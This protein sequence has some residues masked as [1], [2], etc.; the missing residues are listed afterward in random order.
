MRPRIFA[1][2][3]GIAVA[4]PI[5]EKNGNNKAIE[6]TVDLNGDGEMSLS[7]V[8][9]AAFVHHG[10]GGTVVEDLFKQA[11]RNQ[12]KF[13]DAEEFNSIKPLVLAKAENA[14]A[15]YM[16]NVD[17]DRN[18]M[19]S[20][21][22]AQAY[23][24]KE[25]GIGARDVER[26]WKMVETDPEAEMAA[27]TFSKLRRRIR[28]M[29][30]RLA[31]QVM[32][33]AD[34]NS[35][36]H[37]SREEA[38]AIA[39]EQEG[40]GAGD[41][42]QIFM[43]VDDNGDNELNA[44][45]FADFERIVRA[46][47][48]GTSEKALKLM[49]VDNTGTITLNEARQIAF[50]HYGFGDKLLSQ[51]FAQA[52]ENEDGQLNAVEFAGFRSV[53]RA[54]AV[55]NAIEALKA[56]DLDGD[57]FVSRLEA[58]EKTHREDDLEPSVTNS[59]FTIAD[60]NKSGKL[61]KV[62]LA[63]FLRLARLSAI[64]FAAD[65]FKEFDNNQD[66]QVTIDELSDLIT[67]K[68]S[69]PPE[70]SATIFQKVDVDGDHSLTPAEIVDFRH[71]VR[72]YVSKRPDSSIPEEQNILIT[73]TS[74]PEVDKQ[75]RVS[76]DEITSTTTTTTTNKSTAS[77]TTTVEPE[78]ILMDETQN[79]I[80]PEVEPA[81]GFIE[82]MEPTEP[83]EKPIEPVETTS[84]IMTTTTVLITT[85]TTTPTTT[86]EHP[87]PTTTRKRPTAGKPSTSK[88]SKAPNSDSGSEMEEIVE[89]VDANDDGPAEETI[90]YV[91]EVADPKDTKGV[92][93]QTDDS[94]MEVVKEDVE[95]N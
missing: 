65:H 61:D 71:E 47:A 79:E 41:V 68:Y 63:D 21:K 35:D 37:I 28:G 30:I 48:V 84:P 29:S 8:Q 89:Y 34:L 26:V 25:Y 73:T 72:E 93:V 10:L 57:G 42:N 59:L 4:L 9:Y 15:H 85:T 36:G 13:L 12:N 77:S 18:S 87:K 45:E 74:R 83:L 91:E 88:T 80:V 27:A 7:E 56:A 54:R 62:E 76:T 53:I 40:I 39:F 64:K 69:L 49:D 43:S 31:R 17:T 38:Q 19:L 22:E 90:E 92:Q 2:L 86:T 44:P 1:L 52:D 67:A 24:L 70:V 11:D 50:E 58:E 81:G 46:R 75:E 6:L 82:D 32:K 66:A 14:A 3:I 51:F 78:K 95:V 23:I 5:A 20:L 16:Q 60:Q 55:L 33:T 94:V